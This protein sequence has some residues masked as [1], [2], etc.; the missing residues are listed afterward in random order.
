[1]AVMIPDTVDYRDSK[2]KGERLVFQW[3][4][5]STVPGIAFHSLL[6]KNHTHKIM[7]EVDFLYICERGLLCIE[8]KGGQDIYCK[9]KKW[10]S[11]SKSQNEYG[12]SNPFLQAQD[13][14]FALKRYFSDTY[15]KISPEAKYLIGYA[16]VFPECKF[17]GKGNDLVTEV[18][19]DNNYALSGFPSFLAKCFDYWEKL[20][21]E[22]HHRDVEKLTTEETDRIVNLLRGDFRVVPSMNLEMQHIQQKIITL[23]EEQYDALDA[24]KLN[25][26]VIIQGAA[27][28]GKSVLALEKLRQSVSAN[29]NTLYLCYNKNMAKYAK[30]SITN[31]NSELYTVSTLHSLIQN[32][33][34]LDDLYEKNI[35]EICALFI[36]A[37]LDAIVD[38]FDY[39]IVDEAQ[40]LMSITVIEVLDKLVKNGLKNGEWVL[41]LDPNQ[42][43]FTNDKEY[44]F[45]LDYINE[46]YYPTHLLLNCNCRNTEQIAR[47]T[48]VLSLIPPVKYLKISGP[49]VKIV[50]YANP[51]ELK[52]ILR[53]ELVSLFAGGTSPSDLII[54]SKYK[55]NNSGISGLKALNNYTVVEN[56]D[57]NKFNKNSINYYTTQS[58]KGLESNIVFYIDIDGFRDEK[59][60]LINYV[61]MSRAKI[62]LYIFYSNS[63]EEEYN[64]VTVE[65]L[66]LL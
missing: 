22:R 8:V 61:A 34:E 30:N 7:G 44:N 47:S 31:V 58:Y 56:N 32:I 24:T 19:F 25:K 54:L 43:I 6:Q 39:I 33:L 26:R 20:E 13:C 27:G 16:V 65:G 37:N 5:N 1:M 51:N 62:M 29:K 45:A 63:L 17:T 42:N 50:K 11:F 66:D 60:R 23:T 38:R 28:T 35:S 41:F 3:L 9:D 12:I 36:S 21:N 14:M 2:S 48:S 40:D 46:S 52:T 10:Y 57:I 15:G 55:Y 64:D 49:K 4:S 53:Q 59:D 18:M